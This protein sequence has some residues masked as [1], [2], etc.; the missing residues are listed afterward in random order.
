MCVVYRQKKTI[1]WTSEKKNWNIIHA[2]WCLLYQI[3]IA[4]LF[5]IA[6]KGIVLDKMQSTPVC[7]FSRLS[8]V[9][10]LLL[11]N[12]HCSDYLEDFHFFDMKTYHVLRKKKQD[13][14]METEYFIKGKM[15]L[16]VATGF[17]SLPVAPSLRFKEQKRFMFL[18]SRITNKIAPILYFFKNR[19]IIIIIFFSTYRAIK[20][21]P[22]WQWFDIEIL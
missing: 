21:K 1:Y 10:Y 22:G 4:K 16:R 11:A 15:W 12:P 19:C 7:C 14:W 5:L 3:T 2:F 17:D 18:L 20:C 13:K 8:N 6:Y 9:F